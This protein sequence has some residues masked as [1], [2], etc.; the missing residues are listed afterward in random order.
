MKIIIY[1]AIST[2]LIFSSNNQLGLFK[3]IIIPGWGFKE[4]EN[5]QNQSQKHLLREIIVWSSLITARNTSNLFEDYYIS[6]GID[7]SSANILEFGDGYAINVGNYDSMTEYN[8]VMLRKRRPSDVY[9]VNEGYDWEWDS[10][11]KRVKYKK[12]LQASRDLDKLGDFAVAGLIINRIISSI[13]YLYYV[14]TGKNSKFNSSISNSKKDIKLKL[15]Y[16]FWVLDKKLSKLSA[17]PR[18][19]AG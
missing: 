14:Q 9:P 15:E 10:T 1:I 13:N 8:N 6:L 4:L 3:N 5:Y 19:S 16:T 7:H 2:T 17:S 18:S 11:A 12:M